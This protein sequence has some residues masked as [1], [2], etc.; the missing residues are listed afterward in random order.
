MVAQ[1]ILWTLCFMELR[2]SAATANRPSLRPSEQTWFP[3]LPK[4]M[5]LGDSSLGGISPPLKKQ[6]V[7]AGRDNIHGAKEDKV[8]QQ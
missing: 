4:P 7:A 8:H 2:S 1:L 3:P 5:L 6:R